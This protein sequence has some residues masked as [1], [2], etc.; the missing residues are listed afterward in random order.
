MGEKELHVRVWS[1]DYELSGNIQPE[2]GLTL[3]YYPQENSDMVY[4]TKG[5]YQKR[6]DFPQCP[7]AP[8]EALPAR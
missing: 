5:L 3:L 8:F 6:F 1:D 2:Q 4:I 7:R